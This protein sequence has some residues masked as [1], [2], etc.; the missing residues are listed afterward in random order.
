MSITQINTE[1]ASATETNESNNYTFALVSL[2]SLFFIW[3]FITAL[4]DIL[5]PHLKGVFSL[6]YTQTMLV[7]FCFFGAYFI[8]SIPAGKLIKKIG[9]QKGI[10]VGLII[11][12][13]GCL[14]FYPAA[15]LQTYNIF[16]MALFVL[17]SGITILQVSANPYV[18]ALGKAETAS[19]RLTMT[20]AF[21]SLGTTIAPFFGAVLILG[22]ATVSLEHMTNAEINALNALSVQTPYL[23]IAIFLLILAAVFAKIKLPKLAALEQS[24]DLDNESS[25]QS[26][27]SHSHLVLGAIGIFAYVGAEVSIGSFL[28]NYIAEDN[29]A[30]FDE[31]Q[32]AKYISYYWGGAMIGRFIGMWILQKFPAGKVLALSAVAASC[33]ILI[34]VFSDGMLA[35]WSILAIGLFNSIMFPTIFSLAVFGLGTQTSQGSGILCL[36]IVGGA[37]LPL[38]QGLLADSVGIQ[39]SFLMSIIC[40]IYI[41]HFGLKGSIPTTLDKIPEKVG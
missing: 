17:A 11:T 41:I 9:Y 15:E 22:A 20:Q 35:M 40:Y 6:N 28:I 5:I 37:I 16:L 12:S 32:A 30:G 23:L 33:L 4:N 25:T 10:V 14:L 24:A 7:Q 1:F 8:V 21:N 31:M 26:I 27:W 36:A 3:G 39:L 29:I 34:S 18:T 19:S 2:T 38:I 13:L